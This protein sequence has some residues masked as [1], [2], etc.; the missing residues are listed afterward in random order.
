MEQ[1]LQKNND[2]LVRKTETEL[3]LRNAIV[4]SKDTIHDY[5]VSI[6][7]NSAI[8]KQSNAEIKENVDYLDKQA[9]STKALENEQSKRSTITLVDTTKQQLERNVLEAEYNILLN[10]TNWTEEE[11]INLLT[12]Q[13]LAQAEL[14][15]YGKSKAE[16]QVIDLR[17]LKQINALTTENVEETKNMVDQQV[18]FVQSLTKAFNYF[19]D[20]RIKKIDEEIKKAEERQNRYAELAKAG[21]INAQQS[22][23][24]EAKLI[25][26]QNRRKEKLEK[27]KQRVQLASDA[28]V[29]YI[30]N[31]EDPDVK[32]P[33]LKTFSDITL[34]TQ[35]IQNLPF[36][37][38]GTEDTGKTGNGIDGKGGFLSVL[39]PNER[40]M[41]KQQNAMIGDISNDELAK[42]ASLHRSGE[43]LN[44][45]GAVQIESG[46]NTK[47]VV[48][49]LESLENTLKNKPETNIQFERIIDGAMQIVRETKQ[50]NTKVYN[51]YRV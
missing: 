14:E 46:W 42:V 40:V 35:F 12:R 44:G 17:A 26:E 41:T 2:L 49:R 33:L 48:K 5:S 37:E 47:E 15:K 10:E 30:R 32:N 29:A 1:D 4:G 8:L 21:N 22:F 9:N 24:V 45:S 38:S 23:A 36:F 25:A 18:E 20:K 39:H 43:M 3:Q 34:L 19:A 13:I 16:Q 28:T 6:V 27:Q 31:A 7:D 50:G 11:K 51:R